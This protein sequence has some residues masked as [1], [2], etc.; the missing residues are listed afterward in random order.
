VRDTPL[1][2]SSAA[3]NGSA[4]P[5]WR[6]TWFATEI[7]A[8]PPQPAPAL[9]GK[10]LAVV[11]GKPETAARVAFALNQ[12]GAKASVFAPA[13][14]EDL[15]AA[16]EAL[17]LA[18]GG[19]D[20]IVDLGLETGFSVET[21][22]QWESPMRQ[23]VA[24]LQACYQEWQVEEDI[25]RL[26]YLAVTW[27][28]GLMGYGNGG[29]QPLGGLWA[30][31]AKTL[32]QELPNCNVRVLDIAP[33][34]AGQVEQH[35]VREL[36]RWG[37][38]EVGYHQGRRYTLQA[39][40]QE[41]APSP[42]PDLAPGDVVLFSGGAR[43]IGLLCARALAERYGAT[44]IVTGREQPADGSEPWMILDDAGFKRFGQE[45]LRRA[46][47]QRTPVAIRKELSRMQRRRELRAALDEVARCGLLVQ[48]RQCD[49]SDPVAVRQLCDEFGDALRLVIHNAGV[50]RPIRLPQKSLDGFIDTVRV[51]VMGFANLWA[52]AAHRP[53][54]LQFCNMGSLTGRWGGMTGE[55]DYAAANE[56]M[57]RLGLWAQHQTT[58]CCVKTLVW[59]TWDGV[60]MI[61]NL[62]VTKRYVTP[63]AIDE[64]VGHFLREIVD[65]GSGEVMFM[66]AVG[67]ALTPIQIRGFSPILDLHNIASLVTMHHHAGQPLQ[68]RPFR[69]FSTRYVIDPAT[70]PCVHAFRLDGRSALPASMLIEHACVLGDWVGPEDFRPLTLAALMNVH[71]NFEGLLWRSGAESVIQ[72][73][74]EAVGRWLDDEWQVDV[75]CTQVSTAA[76]LLRLTLVYQDRVA[77][78]S[79]PAPGPLRLPQGLVPKIL[80]SPQRATWNAHLLPPAPWQAPS[81]VSG[82]AADVAQVASIPAAQASDL[83]AL[84]LPPDLR[85]PINHLENVLRVLWSAQAAVAAEGAVVNWHIDCLVLGGAPAASAHWLV[86]HTDDRFTV[87]DARAH[88]VL[89]LHGVAL[90]PAVTEPA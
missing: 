32:P 48:Y 19:L 34:D 81:A 85:L 29:Q 62:A 11:N 26:F 58:F 5:A 20:G 18:F 22:A 13:A 24:L 9:V 3:N 8:L 82:D 63:M 6:F 87:V 89:E 4:V 37:L 41:L 77:G 15:R 90:R 38:F 72:I 71:V 59:P 84:P 83:W 12:A 33:T 60:G 31:L 53:R 76:E 88:L 30:G 17:T 79:E 21:A 50:D 10:R 14:G 36:Y 78:S 54:L 2:S 57:A 47:P 52:A 61:T 55:T 51:K 43:G 65:R 25:S 64:G 7:E 35:V 46:T 16:A 56:A 70:A 68:F 69:R 66:G 80:T 1:T 28:D 44:V 67:R 74:S 49:V 40:R 75:R 73:Q 39:R 42:S 27:M 23:T 86:Q 45:Q